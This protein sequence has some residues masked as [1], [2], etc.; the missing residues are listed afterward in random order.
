MKFS[1]S[2]FAHL[3]QVL[4]PIIISTINP[5]L[6]PLASA[7]GSGIVEAESIPG[8]SGADKLKHVL[9]ITDQAAAGVNNA[10]GKQ[11]VDPIGL[12]EAATEA[13]DT[14]VAILNLAH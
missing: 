1:W 3:A 12:H 2:V 13:I 4:A 8:A 11:V 14:T 7:I 9:N 5:K 6:A 10:I